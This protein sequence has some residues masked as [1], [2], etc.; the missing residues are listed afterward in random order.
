MTKTEE[1]E[2]NPKTLIE[3]YRINGKK[4]STAGLTGDYPGIEQIDLIGGETRTFMLGVAES[5][6]TAKATLTVLFDSDPNYGSATA[7]QENKPETGSITFSDIYTCDYFEKQEEPEEPDPEPTIPTAATGE[8]VINCAEFEKAFSENASWDGFFRF[9]FETTLKKT[10][11][12]VSN[13]SVE[14][15]FKVGSDFYYEQTYCNYINL[16]VYSSVDGENQK[17]ASAIALKAESDPMPTRWTTKSVEL[18]NATGKEA[19]NDSSS[20]KDLV[21]DL[22]KAIGLRINVGSGKGEVY[23]RYIKITGATEATVA[24]SEPDDPNMPAEEPDEGIPENATS[25]DFSGFDGW[26][27][28]TVA[29]DKGTTVTVSHI[30]AVENYACCGMDFA[31]NT[32]NTV[33]LKVKNNST[34]ETAYVKINPKKNSEGKNSGMTDATVT[35]DG[36]LSDYKEYGAL[37]TI[38]AGKEVTLVMTLD[39][40]EGIDKLAVSFN[41]EADIEKPTTGSITISDAYMWV[42]SETE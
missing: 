32:N 15:C 41:S 37:L 5:Y 29:D 19:G 26:G 11:L 25:I 40:T 1:E 4:S 12:D 24:P 18:K 33:S 20:Y 23:V 8:Y 13:A 27:N 6:K 3:K 38:T 22:T 28:Y 39:T 14:V 10:A 7:A 30:A 17:N 35:G 31:P 2:G 36:T 9:P 16:N 21:C 34:T 42:A